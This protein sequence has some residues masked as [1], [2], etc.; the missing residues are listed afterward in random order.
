MPTDLFDSF[1]LRKARVH[2]ACG[3]G[4][5]VFAAFCASGTAGQVMWIRPAWST[6]TL[7]PVGLGVFFDPAGFVGGSQRV[8]HAFVNKILLRLQIER[9]CAIVL[10]YF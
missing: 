3:P 4:A 9:F 10:S 7:N 5:T 2:E 1:P 6:A 8:Q